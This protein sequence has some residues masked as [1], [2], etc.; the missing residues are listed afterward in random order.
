MPSQSRTAYIRLLTLPSQCICAGFPV[1]QLMSTVCLILSLCTPKNN[2]ILSSQHPPVRYKYY[3]DLPWVFSSYGKANPALSF[4]TVFIP[5]LSS[6]VSW[7]AQDSTQC[8]GCFSA[9]WEERM[10][11][12]FTFCLH[13]WM[14]L[15][16]FA[17]R[18]ADSCS[19]HL[20][21]GTPSSFAANLHPSQLTPLPGGTGLFIPF[22]MQDFC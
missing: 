17:A 20:P 1:F 16:F 22:Q 14:L 10:K 13:S 11:H 18:T 15:A 12:L 4:L 19:P 9:L 7:G 21:V 3:F 6:L 8:S 5:L 2:L